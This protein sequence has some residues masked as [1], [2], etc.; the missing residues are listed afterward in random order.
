MPNCWAVLIFWQPRPGLAGYQLVTNRLQL[1]QSSHGLELPRSH[2]RLDIPDQQFLPAAASYGYKATSGWPPGQKHQ[3]LSEDGSNVRA[4]QV[5][6]IIRDFVC[7]KC[8]FIFLYGQNTFV[9]SPNQEQSLFPP[10][11]LTP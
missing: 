7:N 6:A 11:V 3:R 4:K 8:V 9:L 1:H 10:S 2:Q 5:S